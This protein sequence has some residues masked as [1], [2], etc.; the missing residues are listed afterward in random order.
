MIVNK[1]ILVR[2][3]PLLNDV[4]SQVHVDLMAPTESLIVSRINGNIGDAVDS[5]YTLDVNTTA[6]IPTEALP[7]KQQSDDSSTGLIVGGSIAGVVVT[8]IVLGLIF[9][10]CCDLD[11]LSILA[12]IC[13][14]VLGDE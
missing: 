9:C 10:F 7:E 12:L 4:A 11:P 14:C 5:T 1:Y 8:L 13:V 2:S 3:R 6:S